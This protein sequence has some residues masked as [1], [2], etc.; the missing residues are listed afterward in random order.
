MV[1]ITPK[2]KKAQT[3]CPCYIHTF[4]AGT[5]NWKSYISEAA[6]PI[7]NKK[8]ILGNCNYVER[9]NLAGEGWHIKQDATLN[10]YILESSN[11]KVSTG[12][13]DEQY[14]TGASTKDEYIWIAPAILFKAGSS[15]SNIHR[16]KIILETIGAS[17]N[18][19]KAEVV[20]AE[21]TYNTQYPTSDSIVSTVFS[22]AAF[23]SAVAT[24]MTGWEK[25]ACDS[26]GADEFSTNGN[27]I[28]IDGNYTPTENKVLYI[29]I[30]DKSVGI[31]EDYSKLRILD[32]E[33]YPQYLDV[34]I[35]APLTY[36]AL[37]TKITPDRG[38]N[39]GK[40]EVTNT[41][42]GL[43]CIWCYSNGKVF[44]KIPPT[45][46]KLKSGAFYLKGVNLAK[47]YTLPIQKLT[48]GSQRTASPTTQHPPWETS[49]YR[50]KQTLLH[51]NIAGGMPGCLNEMMELSILEYL[52]DKLYPMV[53]TNPWYP[54]WTSEGYT[55]ALY[56][57][58][59]VINAQPHIQWQSVPASGSTS[60]AGIPTSWLYGIY[61]GQ[62][63]NASG[64][65]LA[66]PQN[67][68]YQYITWGEGDGIVTTGFGNTGGAD[69]SNDGKFWYAIGGPMS[70]DGMNNCGTCDSSA[71]TLTPL[72]IS[73]RIKRILGPLLSSATGMGQLDTQAINN[74]IYFDT[75]D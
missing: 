36:P 75:W 34:N 52:Y 21:R 18:G 68:Q 51:R 73:T 30:R 26:L 12:I 17:C 59:N 23:A 35:G 16:I 7:A 10:R 63:M 11:S 3:A 28:Q 57:N 64:G 55:V 29:G 47:G 48:V 20:L 13:T 37:K 19:H 62:D 40:I 25:T 4:E 6:G 8:G 14:V 1:Y 66:E 69:P 41:I 61:N 39:S 70:S 38:N 50:R 60:Q 2:F 56:N 24:Q 22:E 32:V 54:D 67:M 42:L 44:E 27:T 9:N 72:T 43:E 71:I 49:I 45:L 15:T 46:D 65:T 58:I 31:D 53:H 33:V 74:G 5:F